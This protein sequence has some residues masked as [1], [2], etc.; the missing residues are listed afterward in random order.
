MMHLQ[1]PTKLLP[2][3]NKLPNTHTLRPLSALTGG[4]HDIPGLP[5]VVVEVVHVLCHAVVDAKVM[6]AEF[7][8]GGLCRSARLRDFFWKRWIG[9]GHCDGRLGCAF[10]ERSVGECSF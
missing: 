1:A 8:E 5:E 3:G 10:A 4:I 9:D 6:L 7:G 2:H